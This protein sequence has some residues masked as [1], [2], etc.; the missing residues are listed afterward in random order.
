MKTK[1]LL[2]SI[3]CALC[4]TSAFARIG[5]TEAQIE[6]RYGAPVEAALLQPDRK[7]YKFKGFTINVRFRDGKSDLELIWKDNENAMAPDVVKRLL[8]ANAPAGTTW[9]LAGEKDSWKRSDGKAIAQLTLGSLAIEAITKRDL[10]RAKKLIE[11]S[12]AEKTKGF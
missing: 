10:D 2:I 4:S 12:E 1:L 7:V 8:D 3:L 11:E 5:E 6:K 9:R